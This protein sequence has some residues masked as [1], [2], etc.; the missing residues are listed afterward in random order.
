MPD[1]PLNAA[2]LGTPPGRSTGSTN[3]THGDSKQ[4]GQA[5]TWVL[6]RGLMREHGHWGDFPEQ[7]RLALGAAHVLTP[8]LPGNGLLHAQTS[9]TRIADMVD[10]CRAQVQAALG[11]HHRP[12]HVLSISMGGM[13]ATAWAHR[14]P[15]EV[16]SLC[17]MASS[18]RPFSPVWQRLRP[19]QWSLILSLL[20]SSASD[21][22]WERGIL[23]MTTSSPDAAKALPH[24]LR[25][26]HERPVSTRNA[27]RQLLA[28]ATF[29]APRQSP[30]M[31]TLVLCGAR[32]ALVDPR[33]SQAIAQAWHCP[34]HVQP[35]AGH[36][37]PLD[38][39]RW[40][41]DQLRAWLQA[42]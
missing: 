38:A 19:Q 4:T 2:P 31:P 35:D 41:I 42:A 27:L 9:P 7:L 14:Y 1:M 37:L 22:A 13:L 23:H 36:D 24:W 15:R 29:S 10:A 25:I 28:A 21:E 16:A 32:D 40:V 33:C 20:L 17:L 3:C 11:D 26:R 6:L 5:G 34:V 12:V 18:M 30:V 8:D 39:P